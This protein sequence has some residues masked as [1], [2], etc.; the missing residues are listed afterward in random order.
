MLSG[1]GLL[2]LSGIVK[3]KP[4]DEVLIE[5]AVRKPKS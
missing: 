5:A 1:W 4:V 3:L 2:S